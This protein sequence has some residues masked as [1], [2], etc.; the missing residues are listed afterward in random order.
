MDN[1]K[2][3]WFTGQPE[4][5]GPKVGA[6]AGGHHNRDLSPQERY[7]RYTQYLFTREPQK[8][9]DKKEYDTL[10][11]GV[12]HDRTYKKGLFSTIDDNLEMYFLGKPEDAGGLFGDGSRLFIARNEP[13]TKYIG[14]RFTVLDRSY[15]EMDQL[16]KELTSKKIKPKD[17]I[18]VGPS[19]TWGVLGNDNPS[20]YPVE[21]V[22]FVVFS[23]DDA[24]TKC[25]LV[26]D[27]DPYLFGILS[28]F[29]MELV[30]DG[31]ID[32]RDDE[33]DRVIRRDVELKREIAKVICHIKE[34]Q[35][36]R[37]D[38]Y[39]H[40][41]SVRIR[42]SEIRASCHVATDLEPEYLIPHMRRMIAIHPRFDNVELID[43]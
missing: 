21:Q 37:G 17:H 9:I 26:D 16:L 24:K 27:A 34:V 22:R 32:L 35:R 38:G 4:R 12:I 31:R 23:A 33:R 41:L 10:R 5:S 7:E 40:S 25:F 19:A 11:A 43:E 6:E 8:K 14:D 1:K 28:S 39:R 3:S 20:P 30:K 2:F 42:I 18:L 29:I 13:K 15:P 36:A